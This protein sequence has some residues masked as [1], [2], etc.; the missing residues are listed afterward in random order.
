MISCIYTITNKIN[1]KIYVGKTYNF[2]NRKSQHKCALREN[3]HENRHLQRAW[4]TYGED[5]FIFEILE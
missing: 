5:S 2:F 4:N 3:T 1:G